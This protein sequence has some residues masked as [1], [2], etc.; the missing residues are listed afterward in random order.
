MQNESPTDSEWTT[1]MKKLET[2]EEEFVRGRPAA[3]KALWSHA[4]DVTLCGGFGGRAERGWD[5]VA[6]R[7]DWASS[8]YSDGSRRT[9][10]ISGVVAAGFAYLVQLERIRF[11]AADRTED[12]NLELRATMVFRREAGDWRIVHRHADSQ[13][14]S[15]AP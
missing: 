5:N 2:A 3:F 13:I 7:L 12:L 8:K 10:T 9:E 6:A 11:R 4:D 14:G 1:F 15:Q